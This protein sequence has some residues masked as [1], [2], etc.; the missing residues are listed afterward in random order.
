ML[1]AGLAF[2]AIRY[3]FLDR[4]LPSFHWRKLMSVLRRMCPHLLNLIRI[5]S[6]FSSGWV[7]LFTGMSALAGL[8][9]RLPYWIAHGSW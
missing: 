9:Q 6:A 7:L 5:C 8:Q 3:L 1:A 4:K 2:L